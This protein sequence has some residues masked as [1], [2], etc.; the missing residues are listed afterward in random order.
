ME[1]EKLTVINGE[2]LA[3]LR[4]PPTRFCVHPLLPQGV[5]ILGG[6]PRYIQQK[7]KTTWED[8][9]LIS[10]WNCTAQSVCSEMQLT[11]KWFHKTDGRQYDHFV[12][13]FAET[14]DLTP[15][16]ARAI[17]LELVQREFPN[18]E[19]LVDSGVGA[20]MA[21][22]DFAGN[23]GGDGGLADDLVRLGRSPAANHIKFF[24]IKWEILERR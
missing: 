2:T 23:G 9:R 12:Q 22:P 1:Q 4:L 3:D 24:S 18:L 19:V 10:G 21:G 17:A 7:E 20:G 5:R 13:S 6:V 11:K 8:Q 15:Q 14:D 16:A